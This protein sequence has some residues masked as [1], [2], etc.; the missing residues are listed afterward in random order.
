M[1]MLDLVLVAFAQA[2]EL[3]VVRTRTGVWLSN[4]DGYPLNLRTGR[5]ERVPSDAKPRERD[6][7]SF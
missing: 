3:K 2:D 1:R 7:R 6:D 4:G 5:I